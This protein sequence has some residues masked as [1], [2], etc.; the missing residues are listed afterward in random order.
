MAWFSIWRRDPAPTALGPRSATAAGGQPP[1]LAG[2]YRLGV[3]I[4]S[5]GAALVHDAVDL[6][7]G[8]GVAVKL[9]TLADDLPPVERT[10]WLARLRREADIGRRLQHPDIKIGRAHV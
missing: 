1:L 9:I 8:S 4:G 5:G 2:R 7:T 3:R 6:R 10:D